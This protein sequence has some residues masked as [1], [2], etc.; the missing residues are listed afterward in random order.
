MQTYNNKRVQAYP[1]VPMF[2]DD[3]KKIVLV[4]GIVAFHSFLVWFGLDA[5]TTYNGPW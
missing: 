3:P 1:N 5:K 4:H 2:N